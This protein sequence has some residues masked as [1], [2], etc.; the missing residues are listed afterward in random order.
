MERPHKC[1]KKNSTKRQYL[2]PSKKKKREREKENIGTFVLH[3]VVGYFIQQKLESSVAQQKLRSILGCHGSGPLRP[4]DVSWCVM[5]M[6]RALSQMVRACARE[7]PTC[8]DHQARCH[9]SW[10]CHTQ[11]TSS[12]LRGPDPWH[13]RTLHSFCCVVH[14]E[15]LEIWKVTCRH[16]CLLMS[17]WVKFTLFSQTT[18]AGNVFGN[19]PTK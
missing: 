2:F 11:D 4:L 13:P 19:H 1:K 12:G 7:N 6:I 10:P 17:R 8:S 18:E 14:V 9:G 3:E 16:I 5:V 15:N